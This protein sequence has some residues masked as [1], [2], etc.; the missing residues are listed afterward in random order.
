MKPKKKSSVK[1]QAFLA[2]TLS[3]ASDSMFLEAMYP[4]LEIVK[5][6]L[7]LYN[8]HRCPFFDGK[9]VRK[10]KNETPRTEKDVFKEHKTC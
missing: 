10:R 3:M 6:R 9:W 8:H 1:I 2:I 4:G 7:T 5:G